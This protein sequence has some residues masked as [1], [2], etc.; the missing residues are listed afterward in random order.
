M[1]LEPTW[2]E[3]LCERGID[4]PPPEKLSVPLWMGNT[5]KAQLAH[6]IL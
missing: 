1:Y 6:S 5:V 3:E 2:Y 4:A